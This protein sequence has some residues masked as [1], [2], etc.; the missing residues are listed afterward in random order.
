MEV[1]HLGCNRL[2]IANSGGCICVNRS[3]AKGR[4]LNPD[5]SLT[6]CFEHGFTIEACSEFGSVTRRCHVAWPALHLSSTRDCFEYWKREP[7]AET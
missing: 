5:R 3:V 1:A 2:L 6:P 7:T 4:Y